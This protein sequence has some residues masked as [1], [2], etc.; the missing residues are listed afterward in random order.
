MY[1]HKCLSG[2]FRWIKSSWEKSE[3]LLEY[4]KT[5]C[6]HSL[7]AKWALNNCKWF[8]TSRNGV[9]GGFFL[10]PLPFIFLD[11]S[12]TH[13]FAWAGGVC[14]KHLFLLFFGWNFFFQFHLCGLIALTQGSSL[15]C[16][17]IHYSN[18]WLAAL[19]GQQTHSL[20][21]CGEGHGGCTKHQRGQ[22]ASQDGQTL[23]RHPHHQ[24]Y[25]QIA[26][27]V[28]KELVQD[29]KVTTQGDCK[30]CG[31][32]GGGFGECRGNEPAE[33]LLLLYGLHNLLCELQDYWYID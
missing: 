10:V 28:G 13:L 1:V 18:L 17:L 11:K 30:M 23:W 14:H 32:G 21:S 6:F 26:P 22:D 33:T 12:G 15:F 9:E 5:H 2:Y 25:H 19:A 20:W 24:H 31:M 8:I 16:I 4:L 29:N 27:H 3:H 7:G